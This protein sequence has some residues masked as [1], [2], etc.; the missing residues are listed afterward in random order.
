MI[1]RSTHQ[2]LK[3]LFL[4]KNSID[5]VSNESVRF[6][7]FNFAVCVTNFVV[8][9]FHLKKKVPDSC[10]ILQTT[11]NILLDMFRQFVWI[12]VLVILFYR[13]YKFYLSIVGRGFNSKNDSKDTVESFFTASSKRSCQH[14]ENETAANE[15]EGGGQ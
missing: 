15:G 6:P 3:T 7:A 13:S 8:A 1:P 5:W 2:D 14:I 4:C 12:V 11:P 9:G 10:F